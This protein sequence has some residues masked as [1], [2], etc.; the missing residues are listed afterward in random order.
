MGELTIHRRLCERQ[1]TGS[2]LCGY[3]AAAAAISICHDEEPTGAVDNA[4]WLVEAVDTQLQ[5]SSLAT[6]TPP[7]MFNQGFPPGL[8][9]HGQGLLPLPGQGIPPQRFPHRQGFQ[10][11]PLGMPVP[12]QDLLLARAGNPTTAFPT[13]PGISRNASGNAC[14]QSGPAAVARAG[15]PTTA[16]P[17]NG[18]PTN[19]QA[20][21]CAMWTS[22]R[23]FDLF[24]E[25]R[26][27]R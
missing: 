5:P 6:S 13:S 27:K 20:T 25:T 7:P 4:A 10:G 15:N 23:R 24:F 9:V 18:E 16:F 19:Q 26:T 3:Y 8:P 12:G 2:R 17:T 1:P 22:S 21:L 14:T 11:M